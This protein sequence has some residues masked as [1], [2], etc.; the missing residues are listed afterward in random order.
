MGVVRRFFLLSYWDL[1]V[2]KELSACPV[3][4]GAIILPLQ[5]AMQV[6]VHCVVPSCSACV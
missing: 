3:D 2:A 1:G 4:A 6:R 5:V